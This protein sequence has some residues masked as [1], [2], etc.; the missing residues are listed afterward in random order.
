MYTTMKSS[1]KKY[2]SDRFIRQN[3]GLIIKIFSFDFSRC[4]GCHGSQ[5]VVLVSGSTNLTRNAGNRFVS[6]MAL[7]G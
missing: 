3:L 5:S 4:N 7:W 1:A 2:K 6:C